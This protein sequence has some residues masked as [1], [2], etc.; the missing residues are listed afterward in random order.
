M[1][2]KFIPQDAVQQYVSSYGG[3]FYPQNIEHDVSLVQPPWFP[4][5]APYMAPYPIVPQAPYPDESFHGGPIYPF[6]VLP[7]PPPPPAFRTGSPFQIIKDLCPLSR[8][9]TIYYDYGSEILITA[10][11][12]LLLTSAFTS[13]VCNFTSVCQ[14]P[15]FPLFRIATKKLEKNDEIDAVENTLNQAIAKY[16]PKETVEG[17]KVV[18]SNEVW[19]KIKLCETRTIVYVCVLFVCSRVSRSVSSYSHKL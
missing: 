12:V 2:A 11:S 15:F 6:A 16:E 8:L 4:P 1:Y 7:P 17:N 13:I 18:T 14:L 10:C 5:P 19:L 9:I 3:P